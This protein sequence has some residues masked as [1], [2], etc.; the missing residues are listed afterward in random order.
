M[1]KNTSRTG[2]RSCRCFFHKSGCE[3]TRRIWD[4]KKG[5]TLPEENSPWKGLTRFWA[6]CQADL[7]SQLDL[8][9]QD[10]FGIAVEELFLDIVSKVEAFH[11]LDALL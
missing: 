2:G 8:D 4:H 10:L 7:Q 6:C 9:A 5:Q 11:I 3:G 1:Q